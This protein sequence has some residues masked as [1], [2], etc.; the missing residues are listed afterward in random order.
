MNRFR[1]Y[2]IKERAKEKRKERKYYH[3]HY[4][5]ISQKFLIQKYNKIARR[6]QQGKRVSFLVSRAHKL[7]DKGE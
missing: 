5:I 2:R 4:R 1:F 3:K 7:P 6:V